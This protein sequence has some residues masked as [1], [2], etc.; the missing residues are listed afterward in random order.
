MA[1]NLKNSSFARTKHALSKIWS[2]LIFNNLVRNVRLKAMLQMVD[3]RILIALVL[4]EFATIVSLSLK[5]WVVISTTVQVKKLAL[6]DNEDMRRVEKREQNQ[7]R[8]QYIQQKGSKI[9]EM[10]ECIWW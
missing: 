2:F 1:L 10:W 3:K 8:K 7:M 5:E 4:M 9:I 6:T